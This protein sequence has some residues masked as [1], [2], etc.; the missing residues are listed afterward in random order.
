[1]QDSTPPHL[2]FAFELRVNIAAT[3]ELGAGPDG[4]RRSVPIVGGTFSGPHIAGRVL[5]G[6]ADWQ[7]VEPDGLTFLDARYAI[8]TGDGVRI[9]VRNRGMRHGP[10]AVLARISA[11]EP[12]AAGEYY[13]RTTPCFYPPA[14]KYEWMGRSVFVGACERSADLVVVRVWK[15]A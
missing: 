7:R 6:G 10:P 4:I 1:M 3:I 8:E 2:E 5:P 13:F 12:V 14:G 15:V 11:G 9:E